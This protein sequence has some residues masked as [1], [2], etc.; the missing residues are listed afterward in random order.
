M[1]YLKGSKKRK[2]GEDSSDHG[3]ESLEKSLGLRPGNKY[4]AQS[5]LQIPDLQTSNVP[6]LTT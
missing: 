4:S 1:S 5:K 6:S 3:A 2:R